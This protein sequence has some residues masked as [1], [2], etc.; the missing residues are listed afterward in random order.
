M[1]DAQKFELHQRA[2]AQLQKLAG[3]IEGILPKGVLFC[4]HTFTVGE[5][6]YSSYV[7]NAHRSDMIKALRE[8]ADTLE[9]RMDAPNS[10]I[11]GRRQ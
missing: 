2:E 4:L 8:A 5:G 3:F 7:S 9:R 11:H 10:S 1:D 6:G